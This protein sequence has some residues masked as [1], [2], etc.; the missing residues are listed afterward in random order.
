MTPIRLTDD[1]DVCLIP[2][3]AEHAQTPRAAVLIL[4]GGGY[5]EVCV[6][7]EGNMVAEAF[8]KHGVQAFV[9]QYSVNKGP[10]PKQLQEAALAMKH[11]RDN[12]APYGIDPARVFVLGFSAGGHLAATLGTMWHTDAVKAV[13]GQTEVAKPTGMM[14]LYSVISTE[15]HGFSF[16]HLWQ[17]PTPTAEQLAA[18]SVERHVDRHT[19]PAFMVHTADDGAVDVR[20]ALCMGEA[21]TANGIPYELHIYPSAP[22]GW[23]LADKTT[24]CGNPDWD[25]PRLAQWLPTAVSWM[26]TI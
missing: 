12:A 16:H 13:V 18:V 5:R 20:N 7:R 25:Q 24:S 6:G 1:P 23:A 14:L 10:F 19:C 3:L 26:E 11:I 8:L 4:P 15:H 17:T 9:L 21:L 22:H 2:H